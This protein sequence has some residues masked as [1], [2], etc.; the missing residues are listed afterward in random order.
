MKNIFV[1]EIIKTKNSYYWITHLLTVI[2]GSL[3]F[4]LY[5]A[6]YRNTFD[7]IDNIHIIMDVISFVLPVIISIVIGLNT[8][9]EINSS[10]FF[11]ILSYKNRISILLTKLT[12]LLLSF[13][14]SILV[15][16][17]SIIAIMLLFS[18][19]T[20]I[21]IIIFIKVSMFLF[22]T[23]IITYIFHLFLNYRFGLGCSL[24]FGFF[25][26]IQM[27]FY[28]N[29]EMIGIWQYILPTSWSVQLYREV[30]K[31]TDNLNYSKIIIMAIITAIALLILCIWFSR[32]SGKKSYE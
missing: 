7:V 31:N 18:L 23:N 15:F 8:I 14:I 32:W 17:T 26:T 29:T 4:T 1:S 30:I 28:T 19:Y 20:N 12:I 11:R 22:F 10:N 6:I 5:F 2:I 3:V 13:L 9:L 21:P 24:L 16:M 27:L 25:E